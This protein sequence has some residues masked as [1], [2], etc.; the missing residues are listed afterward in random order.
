M[1]NH[2]QPFYHLNLC[3]IGYVRTFVHWRRSRDH[4]T[5]N[6]YLISRQMGKWPDLI[7][8]LLYKD[9]KMLWNISKFEIFMI[10]AA[11][12][13]RSFISRDA[14][15]IFEQIALRVFAGYIY[16]GLNLLLGLYAPKL[17]ASEWIIKKKRI[18]MNSRPIR[19]WI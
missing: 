1:A 17:F 16:I 14:Y 4:Q 8:F 2:S 13:S 10:Q 15:L 19:W 5:S 3:L 9:H 18:S 7:N 12:C 6:Q 11:A